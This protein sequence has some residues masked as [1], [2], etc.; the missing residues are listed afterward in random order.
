M[1]DKMTK[2]LEIDDLLND[3]LEYLRKI[4]FNIIAKK[5]QKLKFIIVT[6]I[7]ISLSCDCNFKSISS[8]K[9]T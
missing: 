7:E 1:Q 4:S 5:T 6:K 8:I 9:K 3:T 2:F